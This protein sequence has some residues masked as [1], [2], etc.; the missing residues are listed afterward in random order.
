MALKILWHSNSPSTPSGYGNQTKLFTPRLRDAGHEVTISAFYGREGSVLRNEEG[1]LELPRGTDAYGN[2]IVQA[3]AQHVGAELVF[4]LIDPFVL[5]PTIWKALPWA[6][7]VPIDSEPVLP[8]N[9]NALR[10]AR[11]VIAMSRFGEAQLKAAGFAPLYVPHGIETGV[12]KPV[13]RQ[14]AREEFARFTGREIGDQFLVISVAANK[15]MPSRKNFAGML[16][17]FA[18]FAAD[19]PDALFY[20]HT[21]PEGIWQGEPILQLA[22]MYGIA[23]KVILPPQ[24]A[25]VCGMV[26][27]TLMN[28]LYNAA[29]VFMLLSRGEGF[30]IPIVEAQSAGCPVIV[31]DF[32]ANAELCLTGW[33]IPGTRYPFVPGTWQMLAHPAEAA[34]ALHEMHDFWA[35]GT[36]QSLRHSARQAVLAYDVDSV[37]QTYLLPVLEQIAQE[38]PLSQLEQAA[39]KVVRKRH[40]QVEAVVTEEAAYA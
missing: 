35:A 2:D 31:T 7:W 38:S 28:H 34:K 6:A 36:D 33:K 40:N 29:D 14:F 25:I 3:H 27:P 8:H 24:Y 12:Y 19:H 4:S 37:T 13:E 30:G 18:L 16:E 11:W 23:D 17:A 39:E 22:R 10:A 9:I 15:G 5:N 1:L 26:S 20:L 21:E 32:S